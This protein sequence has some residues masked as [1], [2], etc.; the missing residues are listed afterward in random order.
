GP[1]ALTREKRSRGGLCS[2][3]VF[4]LSPQSRLWE[5]GRGRRPRGQVL[6]PGQTSLL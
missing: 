6:D 3:P 5:R 1:S 2:S 4:L